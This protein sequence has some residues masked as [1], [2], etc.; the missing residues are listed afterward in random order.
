MSP[1]SRYSV[2]SEAEE[3]PYKITFIV[4]PSK[5][6]FLLKI[7]G[8]FEGISASNGIVV[9]V[10]IMDCEGCVKLDVDHKTVLKYR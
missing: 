6:R 9:R 10:N 2:P 8:D 7:K 5:N 3:N 1:A 4:Y